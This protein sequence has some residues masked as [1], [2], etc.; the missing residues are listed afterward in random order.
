MTLSKM[1]RCR[2]INIVAAL[3]VLFGSSALLS[4][5]ITLDAA[6]H[7]SNHGTNVSSVSCTLSNV[8]AGDLITVE[9]ADRNGYET[10]ISDGS[11]GSYAPVY[12]TSD[13]ADP[14]YSG[15][16]Y[17]VNSASGSLTVQLSLSASDPWAL[18]SVQAWKGAATISV[19]E[20]AAITQHQTSTSGTVANANCGT[21]QSPIDS[22][23]LILSYLV[24]HHDTSVTAGSSFTLIDAPNSSDNPAFPEYSIQSTPQATNG[25]FTSSAD[26]WTVGCAAFR[27]AS[28]SPAPIQSQV[29]PAQ[30]KKSSLTYSANVTAGNALYAVM[31]YTGGS[32]ATLT[33]SDSQGNSW[34]TVKSGSLTTA[35]DT[36]AVGCA[37]V[38]T[39]GA[40]T[41]SFL[42]NGSHTNVYGVIYE[43][44]NSTCIQ[45]VS[46]VFSD[47]TAQTVCNS[48]QLTTGT[49]KDLLVG[50]C[51]LQKAQSSLTA[52]TGWS[53]AQTFSSS[54]GILGLSELQVAAT[55]GIYTATSGTYSTAGEQGAIEIAFRPVGSEVGSGLPTPTLALSNSPSSS[56]YGQSVTFTATVSSGPSGTVTFYDNGAVIGTAPISGTTATFSTSTLLVG[57]HT[58]FASWPGNSSYNPVSSA[59]VTQTVDKA[60]PTITWATPAPI[61][62]GVALSSTQENATASVPGTFAYHP[63][64]GTVLSPGSNTL[65][66][67]FTPTDTSDYATA[68]DAVTLVVSTTP[69]PGIITTI[70]GDGSYGDTGDGGPAVSAELEQAYG[71]AVDS[72]E[73]VYFADFAASVIRKI[74][75]S[76]G[77]IT[78]IAG[79]GTAGYSGDGGPASSAD[80]DGPSAIAFDAGGNLYIADTWN[81]RIRKID[82][83]T[84]I[85]STVVGTA[86]NGFSG[87]GGPATSAQICD[88]S[89][90]AFDSSGNLYLA[91]TS[92][93]VVRKVLASTGIITTVVGNGLN[94]YSGDGG[95]ATSAKLYNPAGIAFDSSGNLYIADDANNVIRKVNASTNIISTIAGNNTA[96][97]AGDG[98]AATSAK[99]HAPTSVTADAVGDVFFVDHL[100]NVIRSVSAG[101]GIIS[102]F[103]GTGRSGYSGDGG[104]ATAAKLFYPQGTTLDP[105]GNVYIGDEYRVRVVGGAPSQGPVSIGVSPVV[106]TVYA[107]QTKQFSATVTNTSNTAVTWS[108]APGSG[109][110]NVSSNGLYTAPATVNAPQTVTLT[111]TSMADPT[112]SASASVTLL[113]AIAISINPG[114]ATLH[115]GEAVAFSATVINAEDM[116]VNW[117]MNPAGT[118]TLNSEGEY[119]APA[120]ITT[121]QTVTVTATSRADSTILA[122]ATVTL[123]PTQC[124]PTGYAYAREITID[125]TKVQGSDQVNFPFLLNTT[126]PTFRST[127]SGGHVANPN[128]YDIRFTSDAAGSNVLPFEQESYNASTGAL[129]YWINIPTVSHST[130]TV[131]YMWYGNP[132]VTTSQAT[133]S[134]VWNSAY[135]AVYHFSGSTLNLND[136]TSFGN[137]LSNNSATS[138]PGTI[139]QGIS[140]QPAYAW[141]GSPSGLPT[142]TSARTI[143]EWF[144]MD[145]SRANQALG[146]WGNNAGGGNRWDVWWT[147]SGIGIET[148]GY[149]AGS[150]LLYD[151]NWHYLA[152][153]NPSGNSD[154]ANISVYVDGVQQTISGSGPINTTGD[155][156]ALGTIP[157]ANDHNDLSGR[158]DEVRIANVSR[159]AGWIATEYNNQSAPS[160]FSSL[161][162][163]NASI[164]PAAVSLYAQQS[165]QFSAMVL[166]ACGSA[167]VWSLP[168]RAPGSLTAGGLYTAPLSISAVQ[169]VT[170][171][172]TSQSDSTVTPNAIVTLL[173]PP[174]SPTLT[175]S[176]SVEPPYVIGSSQQFAAVLKNR[177]GSPVS[178]ANVTFTVTGVNST[179]GTAVT[180]S[181]GR[182]SFTYIGANSGI[183]SIQAAAS[184]DGEQVQ[185]SALSANWILP[186][187]QVSLSSTVGQFFPATSCCAFT[188]TPGTT[189]AFSQVFPTI[190]FN[191]PTGAI[192]GNSTVNV[193]SQPFTDVTVDK[194][195][196]YAGSIIAQGN[197]YQAWTGALREFQAVFTGNII[198]ASG[199][200]TQISVYVDNAFVMGVGGG[201]KSVSGATGFTAF[202]GYPI[203]GSL[204]TSIGGT[205]FTV[206][207]PGPGTYPYELDYVE[208]GVGDASLMMSAGTVGVPSAGTLTLSPSSVQAQPVGGQQSFTVV[209]TDAAGNPVP[210]QS[211]GLVVDGADEFQLSGTTDSSGTVTLNYANSGPGTDQVQAVALVNGMVTYSNQVFVPWSSAPGTENGSGSSGSLT[212]SISAPNALILPSNLPLSGSASDSALPQGQTIAYAWSKV[213]GPADVTFA[214]GQLAT[215][216]AT[217]TVA[218]T[219]QLQLTATDVNGSASAQITVVVDP[220]PG[221]TGGWI[222]SPSYG[223]QVSGIVPITVATGVNL[224]SGTL[225]V[226]PADNPNTVT[227]LNTNTTGSGQ[228]GTWDT[229]TIPNGSYWITLQATNSQSQSEYNLALVTV[230]GN[231]KPGRVTSTVTD[232]VVPAKGLAISIQR[233]YDSLNANKIGDFGYGW[234][235]GTN[236]NLEVNPDDNVTFTLAG[237]RRTF[238]LTPQYDGFLPFYVPVFTPEPGLH[239]TLFTAGSGCSDFFDYVV[240]DGSLWECVGGGLW[241]PPGY[242]YTDPSGTAYTMTAGGQ[243]QSIVDKNGN[244]LTITANGITS[245]TGL[246]APF[247]RDSSGRITQITDPQGNQY[248]YG[249]DASGNLSTVTYPNTPTSSTYTYVSGTHYYESGTDFRGNSLPSTTYY[250]PA[251]TDSY[252]NPLNNRLE[253]VTDATGEKTTYAYDLTAHTTTITYPPDGGGNVG[254]ATTAYNTMGN[255]LSSTDPL[256]HTTTNTYDAQQNLLTTTDPLNHTTCYT[257]DGNGNR[258]SVSYPG[259]GSCT[260]IASITTYNQFSEPT[261]TIDEL[262]NA[263][264]F[265]YDINFNPQNVTDGLGTLA[266]FSFNADGTMHSGAIGF[267]ISTNPSKASQF[268]YD[269]DGNLASRT[270]ALGRVTSYTYNSLGQKTTMVEPLLPGTGASAATTAYSY[271]AFGNLTETDAPLGRTT[272]S[273]YDANGNK[274]SD[275]DALQHTTNYTFDALNRLTRTDY[276]DG[277]YSHKTYDFR[278]NIVDEWDQAQNQT[279]HVYDLAGREVS[280][281]RAYGTSNATTTT[282]TYYDDG[283]KETETDALGHTTTYTCDIAGDLTGVSGVN[284]TFSYGY[285]NARNRTSMTDGN[286]HTTGYVYDA[287]KRLIETDYPDNI[288][289]TNTYDGPGNLASVIDQNGNEIDYTYDAAN[290]LQSV[291]Q[292]NSPNA[293][294][295]I[296]SYSYDPLGNLI[297]LNDA[298]SHLTESAFDLLSNQTSKTL[299]DGTLT[300]TRQYDVAGNLTSLT[301]FNGKTTTYA[302]DNLNRLLRR[303]PDPT[304]G[305]PGVSFTYT[306]TGKRQT[307]TDASG[308]TNYTYDSMDRLITKA[309][310]EGPLTYTYDA[311]G[312]LASMTS[313]HTNGVSVSYTYD[314]LNRLSTVVDARLTGNQTT[315]YGYDTAT[316]VASATYPNGVQFGFNYDE[317]NRLNQIATA[318]TGYLYSL[319]GVGNRKSAT[320]LNN[321][322]VNWAY[323]G[324]NRLTN[325]TISLDPNN[326]NGSVSYGLDPVGNRS[327][328]TSSLSGISSGSFSF[329][330]DDQLVGES[331]DSNGNVT[332]SGGKTFSYNT[333]NQLVS[334]NGAVVQLV[335]DGDGN[336]V[337]KIANGVTT[338]FLVD[339]LNP[340][341]YTQV[342]EELTNGAVSRT[343][344]Y[345]LQRISQNQ[346]ISNTWTPSFYGYDGFGTV[347]Q[348]TNATGTITDT[349]D[350]D[351]FG[352]QV[353]SSGTTTNNYLYRGEQWDSDLGLYYLRARYYNSTTARFTSS[354]PEDGITADPKTL[355]KYNY[356]GGDPINAIDPTGRAEVAETVEIDWH[357]VAK[358]VALVIPAALAIE[359]SYELLSGKTQVWVGLG[360]VQQANPENVEQTGPCTIKKKRRNGCD[361]G[362]DR[363]HMLP[364]QFRERFQECGI[365]DIDLPIYTECVPSRCHTGQDSIHSNQDGEKGTSW[366]ARWKRFL[367]PTG[368]R[369]SC[370]S[371]QEIIEFMF[372]LSDEF[373]KHFLCPE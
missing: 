112:K 285:D 295:N 274:L 162:A 328:E 201:A 169:T 122:T 196:N 347:R 130:D 203:M 336:R 8:T 5:Q 56:S 99:L 172:A 182:A 176:A 181:N 168:A 28:N 63:G 236:V 89:G 187:S 20:T 273:T 21:A 46:A 310:P 186:A 107:G 357:Q 241:T 211:V 55:P 177:D 124:N 212:V 365:P 95:I 84:G 164:T 230:V 37:T 220:Q 7:C 85:I 126:D 279:H 163:E 116:S 106:A 94:G 47:T 183:D 266:S 18:V 213:S 368:D 192:P 140:L 128:G 9:Y 342:V 74:S 60:T 296:T 54:S 226:Y 238:Y 82:A 31:D 320:E 252:G 218:G 340:T 29:T 101:T 11:N 298:N 108:I 100:N 160:T 110:G 371:K 24:P 246:S 195:G 367:G 76:T 61:V 326:K 311:A 141:N 250:G 170:I 127:S 35:G 175:L 304:T 191:P 271:D 267:D 278:G 352:N 158:L 166:N 332:A 43:V 50:M 355:H 305:E 237:Q 174:S 165:Q 91:D 167:V 373:Q 114:S 92:N 71:I 131:I 45:D 88:P 44:S 303:T 335:Y 156:I 364:Q 299:P 228:I 102:T 157:G 348:L 260:T 268:T 184:V 259:L 138:T 349:Y 153:T 118:G 96:G 70:A 359:C 98:G 253:S 351:A 225:T 134:T 185:S 210:N 27:R 109:S 149:W 26:D 40:D 154:L 286:N 197:G 308:T 214:N 42:V 239:G 117:T 290:Q 339:D 323:D 25:P 139:G 217:F 48:G 121:Q 189:P 188:A 301:H 147:G 343:Y 254:T 16:A 30:T 334:M 215:T 72:Q 330:Q 62:Y 263:R 73:N 243:L 283:R 39:S 77:V 53:N 136:S 219:Y 161:S 206:R 148:E 319:D 86:T 245:S 199:G 12:Y 280:V 119:T 282:Y 120:T 358:D 257:Y 318:Q 6:N 202:N 248:L 369:G 307:M 294:N 276:P 221:V 361:D 155:N 300:E 344:T 104:P 244:A 10:S 287:R 33:F 208:D 329:N 171:T 64:T 93:N 151:N 125:H 242:V 362:E 115:A 58:V 41:V 22:G 207:F 173:P 13:S 145:D 316:N 338:Q 65:N 135:D 277:T 2:T 87:D 234:T 269:A 345:G 111:A 262:G 78:T 284:G 150:A 81:S 233:T 247:V 289:K 4:A 19:L 14:N 258:T 67:T 57:S 272:K 333:E 159:S 36:V 229:T 137:N 235:L 293:P 327:S 83:S 321:R 3:S 69:G 113:P 249:Y 322:A 190:N 132:N 350:Y 353:H 204:S 325:E 306:A 222:G 143:S 341:G 312:H 292:T 265:N 152:I 97:Y 34:A 370:P 275:T 227:V 15:I 264:S 194:S 144:Q 51:G 68:T 231:Y 200:D 251:D 360:L 75:A 142:G 302:Y 17:F 105:L 255:L 79:N 146:G 324:I 281:T 129:I 256:G 297:G 198:V 103:A 133:P 363:H 314:G 224:T 331:Y 66:V 205:T 270:D 123:S 52:G 317:L 216:T 232:L 193:A 59:T 240:P 291:I 372:Y 209:A 90:I 315:T 49:S 80:L 178:N 313:S 32:E 366:N 179:S 309:A 356:A 223:G 38:G 288:K 23:E 261:Q 1:I 337:R 180:D 346:V 354:D